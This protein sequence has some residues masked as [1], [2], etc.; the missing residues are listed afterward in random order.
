MEYTKEEIKEIFIALASDFPPEAEQYTKKAETKKAY[1]TAG[2]GYQFLVNRFNEVLGTDWGYNYEIVKNTTGKYKDKTWNGQVTPGK[3][4]YEITCEMSIWIFQK[5]NI[6]KHVGGHIGID[7]FDALKGAI[8]NS[9]KKCS[10][11]WGVGNKAYLGQLDEDAHYPESSEEKE[12]PFAKKE[13]TIKREGNQAKE[14][15]IAYIAKALKE[16]G[17]DNI[18]VMKDLL[19]SYS[20]YEHFSGYDSLKNLSAHISDKHLAVVYGKIKKDYE[21]K[22]EEEK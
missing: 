5:E 18:E 16:L 19:Q 6:R 10:A 1:D 13:P 2:Y 9:F 8:T 14:E 22:I 15:K 4:F 11:M 21:K 20:N 12:I 3:E 7:Y 17:G